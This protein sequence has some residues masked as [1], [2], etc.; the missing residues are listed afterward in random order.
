M[1]VYYTLDTKSNVL[2]SRK[3]EALEIGILQL[4]NCKAMTS[5]VFSSKGQPRKSIVN[6]ISAAGNLKVTYG[7]R[8]PSPY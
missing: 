7:E 8:Q 3:I 4:S 2:F 1:F 6:L 5:K